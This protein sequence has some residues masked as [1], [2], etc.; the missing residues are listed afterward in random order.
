[1]SPGAE[2]KAVRVVVRGRVQ[3]VWFR[4]STARRAF[5]LGVTGWVRNLPDGSVQV[6]AEGAPTAVDQLVTFLHD[7]PPR[8]RVDAL[9][10]ERVAIEGHDQFKF[11]G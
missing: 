2:R 3:G 4:D 8:A 10:I 5:A 7:G 6:H 9:D 11:A 1:M